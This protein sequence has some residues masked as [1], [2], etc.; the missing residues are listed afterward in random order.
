MPLRMTCVTAHVP[1]LMRSWKKHKEEVCYSTFFVTFNMKPGNIRRHPRSAEYIPELGFGS[2]A[3][4]ESG[5]CDISLRDMVWQRRSQHVVDRLEPK[6]QQQC[7]DRDEHN[8]V[9][10]R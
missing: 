10:L 2:L 4:V 5:P 1:R 6:L 3:V 9:V 7:S 8:G